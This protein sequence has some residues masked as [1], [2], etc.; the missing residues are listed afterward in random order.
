[1]PGCCVVNCKNSVRKGFRLYRFPMDE[2]RRKNWADI[3]CRKNW[4]PTNASRICEVTKID[5]LLTGCRYLILYR[6][7]L[8]IHNLKII[9]LMERG[10]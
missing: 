5:F 9:V 3:I 2:K 8:K 4:K 7:I 1:M 6:Y 10:N